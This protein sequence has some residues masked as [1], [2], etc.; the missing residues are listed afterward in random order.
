MAQYQI[1][2]L[3]LL[4]RNVPVITILGDEKTVYQTPELKLYV[5]IFRENMC[6]E[7]AHYFYGLTPDVPDAT[8][9]R[10]AIHGKAKWLPYF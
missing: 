6:H 7:L 2:G 3:K 10:V 4:G 5:N 1:L 8:H 9:D